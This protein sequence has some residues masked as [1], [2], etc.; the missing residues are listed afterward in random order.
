MNGRRTEVYLPSLV[1]LCGE[2][3]ENRVSKIWRSVLLPETRRRGS[4]HQARLCEG[5]G[6]GW[7]GE[8]RSDRT[9]S[10]GN[11]VG[12][13]HIDDLDL[14]ARSSCT[15]CC[16]VKS[17]SSKLIHPRLIRFLRGGSDA[18]NAKGLVLLAVAV[19]HGPFSH[20]IRQTKL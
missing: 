11:D 18:W 15:A 7:S 20:G 19:C 12:S 10:L 1:I 4:A 3:V 16:H 8:R 9:H 2:R 5:R 14:R 17:P 13:C 6:E